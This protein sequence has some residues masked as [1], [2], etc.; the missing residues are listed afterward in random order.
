MR[1]RN[2]LGRRI[3]AIRQSRAAVNSNP[4]GEIVVDSIGLDN[5]AM[6]IPTAYECATEPIG[7]VIIGGTVR[8]LPPDPVLCA[9]KEFLDFAETYGPSERASAT[10]WSGVFDQARAALTAARREGRR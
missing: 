4:R 3:V 8:R 10:D 6:L 7:S 5:G 9:L 1:T 2:I